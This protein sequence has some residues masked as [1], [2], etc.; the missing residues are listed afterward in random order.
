MEIKSILTEDG[1]IP[2]EEYLADQEDDDEDEI[3]DH[4]E[5]AEY[6]YIELSDLDWE[7]KIAAHG[8]RKQYPDQRILKIANYRAST[9]G[10]IEDW[11]RDNCEGEWKKIG[12]RSGCHYT[13]AMA[14][15]NDLDAVTF[16]L[17]WN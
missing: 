17:R 4:Y 15:W 7:D 13:V 2:I 9:F 14:F 6:G 3:E 12:W 1:E 10:E 16:R 11:C 8:I 5:H